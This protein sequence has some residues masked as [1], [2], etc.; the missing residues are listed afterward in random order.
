MG[1]AARKRASYQ[2]VLDAPPNVV[3]EVLFGVLHTNPRPGPA[4]ARTASVLGMDLGGPFDRGRGGPGGW[5]LLDEPE[6]H[7][8]ED[9]VVP[10]LAG[11]RKER[12]ERPSTAYFTAAPDFVCEV[13]SRR[14]E[15]IDRADKMTIYAR[16][17]V[18]HAWLVDPALRTLE[19]YRLQGR[20]WLRVA[21]FGDEA[22]ARA[23]PFDAIEIELAALWLAEPSVDEDAS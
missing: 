13:L 11:W 12:F 16:E 23:E 8:G 9:I 20:D 21:V 19:V 22:R 7:L 5:V 2:D 4:H 10:D 6:L 18:S 14:T 15:K 1:D 3:A 17:G